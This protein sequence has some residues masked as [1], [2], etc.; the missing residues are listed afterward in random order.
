MLALLLAALRS[1]RLAWLVLGLAM[2]TAIVIRC[3]LWQRYGED[4]E[5]YYRHI[6]YASWC[7]FD[8]LL[9]GVAVALLQNFHP[10]C[11]Q[12]LISGGNRTL[13]AGLLA[14]LLT[15]TLFLNFHA[16]QPDGYSLWMTALGYPLLACSFAL[17]TLAALSPASWLA[18]LRV[19]GASRLALWSYAIYLTHK[20]VMHLLKTQL[21]ARA[22]DPASP[23]ALGLMMVMSVLAGW[24][25]Y[26][27][28]EAP[29]M[30][31]RER[32]F[33]TGRRPPDRLPETQVAQISEGIP[34]P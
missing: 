14:T 15:I 16:L 9:P 25:L 26:V 17:L 32:W 34:T 1:V 7:R 18:R 33:D 21:A 5:Q 13:C 31:L 24:L 10:A 20:G 29:C 2:G 6:Y 11:W 3:I 23:L 22:I 12:R 28:V 27:A 4:G 30:R 8:E 19:A